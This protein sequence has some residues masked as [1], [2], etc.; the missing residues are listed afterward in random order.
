MLRLVGI[1]VTVLFAIATAVLTWP[2]FFHVE[3][4][5]PIAQL[6][7]LRGVLVVA[8]ALV[9]IV[10]LLL[11]IAR[12]LRGFALSMA[13]VS[14]IGAIAGGVVLGVRGY[15]TESLP[16][17]TATS[18]RVMTWNTAGNAMGA[19]EIAETA[20][21]MDVDIVALPETS[22]EVGEQVAVAMRDMGSPM[23]VHHVALRPDIA[24]GPQAW[25]TTVL[26]SPDLGDYSVIE[27][28]TDLT[29]NTE[30]VPSVVAM[31][32]DGVGPT[33]VAVHAV[34]PQPEYMDQWVDDLQ[35]IADQCAGGDVILAGDFNATLDNMAG[36]G[37]DG[38]DLGAC[39]DAA[40]S[41]GN[42]AV[43]T[44]PTDIPALLST[45]IDHVMHSASWT[46]T[47]SLVL[48]NLD[49]AGSDHRPLVVQLE[50]AG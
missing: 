40:A 13:L 34:S 11:A 10:F 6:A 3:R 43:G 45:P 39:V 32:V 12:P 31:P 36:L 30:V 28:S 9:T 20:V 38:G 14:A 4:V 44:W 22:E 17:A 18:V 35:W 26:I 1:L 24:D 27:A 15:G 2:A 33:V 50:P 37:V 47:G 7:A 29:S 16:D 41:T 42:G 23:W 5:F 46:A 8:F 49:D 25:V 21:A 19:A 48:T